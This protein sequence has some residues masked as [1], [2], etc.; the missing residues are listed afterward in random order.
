[1][2]FKIVQVPQPFF[3]PVNLIRIGD[4]VLDTGH[5]DDASTKV[6]L[7]HFETGDLKGVTEVVVTH[8]H[9]DHVG[10]SAGVPTLGEMP[11]TVLRGAEQ[12]IVNLG[13]YMLGA[14]EEQKH[15]LALRDPETAAMID[16]T[17]NIYFPADREYGS[18]NISRIVD[19]GDEI[20][21]GEACLRVIS[22]PGHE[23][24]HMA[25][26]HEPSSTVFSGDLVTNNA[27]FS[28]TPLTP[29]IG[30]YERSL[31]KLLELAP[32]R[33]VPSHGTVIEDGTDHLRRCLANVEDIKS[34]VMDALGEMGEASHLELGKQVFEVTDPLK[35]VALVL[36]T[37]CYL[38][39]L[40]SEGKVVLDRDEQMARLS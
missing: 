24:N 29:N 2:D 9:I 11:H 22:T 13:E 10:A 31:Y 35:R 7:E 5:V 16:I 8:P 23:A 30:D 33:I 25:L 28:R 1:M 19:P 20:D 34:R 32:Q 38:E 36:V 26:Y 4:A 3:E 18:V 27:Q 17:G 21:L 14:R 6:V 12:V 40:E 39:Y 37:W 15:L